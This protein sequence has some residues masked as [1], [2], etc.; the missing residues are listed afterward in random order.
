SEAATALSHAA[1]A[2]PPEI[3]NTLD[4]LAEAIETGPPPPAIPPCWDG[5]PGAQVLC[6]ALKGAARLVSGKGLPD[7]PQ[8]PPRSQ[9]ERLG[10]LL[11]RIR[12][13]RMVRLF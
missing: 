7:E 8:A 1:V 5:Q 6:D 3:A 10:D 4:D 9:R 13:G 11:D 2:P 12:A